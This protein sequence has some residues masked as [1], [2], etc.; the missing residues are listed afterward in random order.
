M[1]ELHFSEKELSRNREVSKKFDDCIS[2]ESLVGNLNSMGSQIDNVEKRD[3]AINNLVCTQ[4]R[5]IV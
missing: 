2:L 5:L 1:Y 3:V 4:K